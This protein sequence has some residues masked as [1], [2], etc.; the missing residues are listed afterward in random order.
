MIE[1]GGEWEGVESEFGVREEGR[2]GG[3]GV[4]DGGRV[5]NKKGKKRDIRVGREKDGE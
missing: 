2:E 5:R 1:R 3:M 4:R